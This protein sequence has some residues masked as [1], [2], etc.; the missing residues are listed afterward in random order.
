MGSRAASEPSN[1]RRVG[2]GD[3]D[4]AIDHRDPKCG[5]QIG[6]SAGGESVERAWESSLSDAAMLSFG[7]LALTTY[8]Q[9]YNRMRDAGL[10]PSRI[11]GEMRA[12]QTGVCI[13]GPSGDSL[14]SGTALTLRH[15]PASCQLKSLCIQS[16]PL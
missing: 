13:R 8:M 6:M 10:L 3:R 14:G 1:R 15:T 5:F 2:N 9:R 12:V 4:F 7:I 11:L 16:D